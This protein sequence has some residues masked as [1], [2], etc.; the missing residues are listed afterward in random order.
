MRQIYN[1]T[2][3]QAVSFPHPGNCQLAKVRGH[4]GVAVFTSQNSRGR[5][6]FIL[7]LTLVTLSLVTIYKKNSENLRCVSRKLL[8]SWTSGMVV[9]KCLA[10]LQI[11]TAGMQYL[12]LRTV[13]LY[14]NC[15]LGVPDDCWLYQG[16]YG[17]LNSQIYVGREWAF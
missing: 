1:S 10:F 5:F 3:V 15:C 6:V 17:L 7:E 14:K 12:L 4:D 2:K 16:R 9:Q 8:I 11:G 13:I